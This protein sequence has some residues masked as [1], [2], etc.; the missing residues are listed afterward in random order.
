MSELTARMVWGLPGI[1]AAIWICAG[2]LGLLLPQGTWD[3]VSWWG[4][5]HGA[6]GQNSARGTCPLQP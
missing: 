3:G 1:R 4:D 5:H 2:L 6:K